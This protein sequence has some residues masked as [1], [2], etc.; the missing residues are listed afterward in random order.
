M[1]Q[2]NKDILFWSSIAIG[3]FVLAILIKGSTIDTYYKYLESNN[4]FNWF[5]NYSSGIEQALTLL[6]IIS[7]IFPLIAIVTV[8]AIRHIFR[9]F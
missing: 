5:T 9:G 1:K 7:L 3:Y 8:W 6:A 4:F 2:I